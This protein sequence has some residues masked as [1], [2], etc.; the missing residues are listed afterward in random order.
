MRLIVV[1]PSLQSSSFYRT[2]LVQESFSKLRIVDPK[3]NTQGSKLLP[4]KT[5]FGQEEN[6]KYNQAH[7]Q[8]AIQADCF[9]EEEMTNE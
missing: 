3:A 2:V 9:L 4:P 5:A 1:A 6:T 8:Y 7:A